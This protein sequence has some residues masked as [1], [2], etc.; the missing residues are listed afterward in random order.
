MNWF[1]Q[2]AMENDEL[3]EKIGELEVNYEKAADVY[4]LPSLQPPDFLLA[5]ELTTRP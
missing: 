4:C 1:D 5:P 3:D 2:E